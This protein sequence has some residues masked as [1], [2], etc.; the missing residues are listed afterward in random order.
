MQRFPVKAEGVYVCVCV[1]DL[2]SGR[3]R[4]SESSFDIISD[5][6][7]AAAA[8]PQFATICGFGYLGSGIT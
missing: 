4:F 6:Y 8:R 2:D 5:L 1:A 7:S 3:S